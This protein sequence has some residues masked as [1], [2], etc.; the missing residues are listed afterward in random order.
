MEASGDALL[1]S[2]LPHLRAL[3]PNLR[4]VGMG[5]PLSA[6]AGLEVV[7]DPR[8]LAAHGL[9]EAL[10]ALPATLR[11]LRRLRALAD[12]ARALLLVDAPELNTRLLSH[13]RARA[14]PVAYLAPPQAWA[15]R[16]GR[17]RLLMEA[18]WVGCLF[19][20]EAEWYRARGAHAAE[21]GHPLRLA[22]S[23]RLDPE[24]GHLLLC[25]GSR[26]SA[27]RRA[28]PLS[29]AALAALNARRALSGDPP[30]RG[31]L[32]LS[33]WLAGVAGVEGEARALAAR[34]GVTLEV[35][36]GMR[37]AM[38][39]ARLA[40]CHAGTATLEL[41]LAGLPFVAIA[42]LSP[43]SA[44]VARALVR[45]PHYALPNLIL[46]ARVCEELP[47]R[48]LSPA[49][50]AEALER[51]LSAGRWEAARAGLGALS[52]RVLA[53]RAQEVALDLSRALALS[54]PNGAG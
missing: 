7:V 39:G 25:P 27:A 43:L 6:A 23:P 38:E 53:P 1:A 49:A 3:H 42:P 18:R 35:C 46:G 48:P 14:L 13:A 31:V 50:A 21:V 36:L 32:A 34:L 51:L 4:W 10:G 9:T 44:A 54:A 16:P 47:P 26:A 19:G 28:L 2:L 22:P 8:P 37:E 12:Q 33:P 20:F 40:L 52:E 29:L 24:G 30:L 11:A 15:W 17:A 41:G 45:A 5:G